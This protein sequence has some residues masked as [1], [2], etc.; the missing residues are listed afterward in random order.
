MQRPQERLEGWRTA[1]KSEMKPNRCGKGRTG[2]AFEDV[3]RTG[4]LF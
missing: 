1:D 3:T 2:E 4:D